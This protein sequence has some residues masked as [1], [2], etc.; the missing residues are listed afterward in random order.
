MKQ[1]ETDAGVTQRT[2]RNGAHRTPAPEPSP[3]A[4][5]DEEYPYVFNFGYPSS[6]W[7]VVELA[8]RYVAPGVIVDLGSGAGTIAPPLVEAG[9]GY[10]GV[11][12]HP[13]ALRLLDAR[14]L[15]NAA[16][17]LTDTQTLR[18]TLDAIGEAKAY[19]LVDVLEHLGQPGDLLAF[20]SAYALTHGSPY[21][22]ISVPNVGHRD[23]AY[24]LLA[25]NWN[26]T[27]TGLLDKTHLRFFTGVSLAKMLAESGWS[28]VARED[29]SLPESDQY[30]PHSLLHGGT[31]IGDFLRDISDTFNPDNTVN[32]FIW[33]LKPSAPRPTDKANATDATTA[34]ETARPLLSIGVRTQGK[35]N[36]LLLESLFS[37]YG[38][39]CDDYE[40]IVC[41][42]KDAETDDER[43]ET[44]QYLIDTL[45]V[46]LRAKIRVI[47]CTGEGRSVPL[48]AIIEAA[49]GAYFGF[50]DDDDLLFPQ[51][52][53]ML[54]KGVEK[55]GVGPIF[56]TFA[57][58][59]RVSVR[60]EKPKKREF[61]FRS[62]TAPGSRPPVTYPYSTDLI[63]PAWVIP[64]DPI[65]QQYNNDIPNCCFLVPRTLIEQTNLRFRLDFD[66]AEDWEFLMRASQFLKVV[67]MPE[68]T[69]AINVRNNESNTVQNAELQPGWVSA[70]RKRLDE[71]AKRPLLVEGRIAR[72]LFRRH[73][74]TEIRR[75]QVEERLHA[76]ER[77]AASLDEA[78]RSLERE[79]HRMEVD[80]EQLVAW[81]RSLEEALGA[82]SAW[83]QSLSDAL[84]KRATPGR[85]IPRR[86]AR[87]LLGR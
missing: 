68:I 56:Q 18:A 6:Y 47:T 24:N 80:R 19:C 69:A 59:R 83:G 42:H 67:T 16:C 70:H 35:R 41:F 28:L 43:L 30:D 8:E 52:V 79:F 49:R 71:Q 75:E 77:E 84:Q 11:E 36:D 5:A 2:A 40:A 55:H 37:I 1:I 4:P 73:I 14:G 39:E 53:A 3:A 25:G 13:G 20:L 29:F 7:N 9:F 48:N 85:S 10:V 51:H 15:R 54:K 86:I 34:R 22:V 66:L 72:L 82:A 57:A 12:Q 26:E 81:A 64:Y 87:L 44:V 60:E 78:H 46:Q 50:L 32:Q 21:L 62:R 45:P 33:L 38:Q 23:V 61:G 17:D 76:K 63:E 65:S 74:E 58:R 31:Q 27:E